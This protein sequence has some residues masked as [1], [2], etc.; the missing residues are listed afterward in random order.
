[1]DSCPC[2][3]LSYVST[4][5]KNDKREQISKLN[6]RISLTLGLYLYSCYAYNI[7]SVSKPWEQT[8]HTS[9]GRRPLFTSRELEFQLVRLMGWIWDVL[10][11]QNQLSSLKIKSKIVFLLTTEIVAP[12]S[13]FSV[14]A[15]GQAFGCER[16][17]LGG[18]EGTETL[19][20]TE[21]GLLAVLRSKFHHMYFCF[22]I[23]LFLQLCPSSKMLKCYL[24]ITK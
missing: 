5:E 20:L 23:L 15:P 3:W 2:T 14:S 10:G 7:W 1:M 8:H 13:Q 6:I 24:I 19:W 21:L 12:E 9:V 22:F 18:Q 17:G 16:K 4:A 11:D